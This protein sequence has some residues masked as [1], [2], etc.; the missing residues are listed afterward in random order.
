MYFLATLTLPLLTLENLTLFSQ[1]WQT[2]K[3]KKKRTGFSPGVFTFFFSF[4]KHIQVLE[5]GSDLSV[6]KKVVV[7]LLSRAL[8][9][10]RVTHIRGIYI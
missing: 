1:N 7:A 2:L 9:L 10:H 6:R 8:L 4:S 5:G 3:K